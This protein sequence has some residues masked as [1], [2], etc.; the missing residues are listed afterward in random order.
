MA[1]APKHKRMIFIAVALLI[2][3]IAVGIT[4]YGFRD[5]LVFFYTPSQLQERLEKESLSPDTRL[6]IGGLVK[7]GSVNFDKSS[8]T[9]HFVV[10]DLGHEISV[11]YQG[12]IPALFREGQGVVAEGTLQAGEQFRAITLLAK[13]DENYMP[14]QVKEQLKQSGKWQHYQKQE[15]GNDTGQSSATG[16]LDD[17]GYASPAAEEKREAVP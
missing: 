17:S 14:P 13:H 15:T 9:L 12:I 2:C 16:T 10:T 3:G 8:K 4:L 5:N 6:R 11:T 1:M 7:E